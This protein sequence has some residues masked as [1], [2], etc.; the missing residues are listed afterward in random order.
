MTT[1]GFARKASSFSLVC[2]LRDLR[3][4]LPP[5]LIDVYAGE[6]VTGNLCGQSRV[7]PTRYLPSFPA[8]SKPVRTKRAKDRLV[9][10]R[11]VI[12]LNATS[13]LHVHRDDLQ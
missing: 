6:A 12:A 3:F 9:I 13:E 7:S 4:L 5:V 1:T 10:L 11:R 8:D 2:F